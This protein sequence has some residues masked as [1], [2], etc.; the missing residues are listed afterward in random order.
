[1]P[2]QSD[3]PNQG[4]PKWKEKWFPLDVF[5]VSA[6]A[7]MGAGWSRDLMGYLAGRPAVR[8]Y[9]MVSY[10]NNDRYDEQ[11]LK[12]IRQGRI[13]TLFIDP[14]NVSD[15][16]GWFDSADLFDEI[17][18]IDQNVIVVLYTWPNCR[19][20]FLEKHPRFSHYFYYFHSFVGDLPTDYAPEEN[21][22]DRI[23]EK[24]QFWHRTRHEYDIAISFAG[25]DRQHAGELA[26]QLKA[27]G[28]RIFYDRFEQADLL[29]KNL[30]N[31]FMRFTQSAADM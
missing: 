10:N 27:E 22:L 5:L 16:L 14:G 6:H 19:R 21:N 4:R 11:C 18:K 24:C 2:N 17:K 23:M 12:L 9:G 20:L 1:M 28:A 8:S 25:E 15:F 31:S 7:H 30:L 13:N 29:G 26:K 3:P